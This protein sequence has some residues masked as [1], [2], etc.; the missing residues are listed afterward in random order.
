MTSKPLSEDEYALATF[1]EQMYLMY[2]RLPDESTCTAAGHTSTVYKKSIKLPL[3]NLYF[4]QRGIRPY[5]ELDNKGNVSQQL[6]PE[7]LQAANVILNQTD[8]RSRKKKLNDLRI[9]PEKWETWLR[10]PAFQNYLRVRGEAV[11]GDHSHDAH[12][13]LVERVQSGD[14]AAIKYYNEITGRFIPAKDKGIDVQSILLRVMEIIQRR[15]GDGDV[16]LQIAD[17]LIELAKES[18]GQFN[19]VPLVAQLRPDGPPRVLEIETFSYS[20]APIT[21]AEAM[22]M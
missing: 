15:V 20:D 17:D 5:N 12:L 16:Q 13:G 18:S 11:L 6:S 7:Q 8:N 10:D 4:V 1:C 3:F 2:G 19:G 22:E 21:K 14:L 9:S